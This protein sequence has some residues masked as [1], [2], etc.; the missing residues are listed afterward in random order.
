MRK[1]LR[2]EQKVGLALVL[3]GLGVITMMAAG[4]GLIMPAMASTANATVTWNIPTD[5]TISLSY[6]AN[7]TDVVFHPST[8]TFAQLYA[9]GQGNGTTAAFRITN[10]G[11]VNVNIAAAFTATFPTGVAEF[12]IANTS[13]AGAPVGP[14]GIRWWCGSTSDTGDTPAGGCSGT[15]NETASWTI[16]TALIPTG[17]ADKW[18]WSWGTG[19]T[20]GIVKRTFQLTSS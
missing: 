6:P 10:D 20:P 1:N 2:P 18:A 4:P 3:L 8:G 9:A 16:S 7:T 14:G 15:N 13:T 12:R 19:V 5:K 11:N 17:T